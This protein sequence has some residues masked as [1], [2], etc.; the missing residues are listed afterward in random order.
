MGNCENPCRSAEGHDKVPGRTGDELQDQ[1]AA[2]MVQLEHSEPEL[3]SEIMPHNS[4]EQSN[5]ELVKVVSVKNGLSLVQ[6]EN[7]GVYEG[8]PF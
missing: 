6:Y 7:G 5:K 2:V 8:R 4:T 3:N 1:L